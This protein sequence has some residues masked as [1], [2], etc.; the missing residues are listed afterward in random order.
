MQRPGGY[1]RLIRYLILYPLVEP[2][3]GLEELDEEWHQ[4]QAAHRGS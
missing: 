1:G 2:T 3:T 4:A